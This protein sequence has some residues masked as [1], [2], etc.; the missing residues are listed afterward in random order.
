MKLP[1]NKKFWIYPSNR[2]IDVIDKGSAITAKEVKEVI[3]DDIARA[4][5]YFGTAVA[6]YS[7]SCLSDKR[8]IVKITARRDEESALWGH[9]IIDQH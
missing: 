2:G 4:R 3:R 8:W 5:A 6:H 9:W 1:A 7:K